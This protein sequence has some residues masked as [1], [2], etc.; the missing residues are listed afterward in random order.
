MK[1]GLPT[2]FS[3]VRHMN[4]LKNKI[5]NLIPEDLVLLDLIEDSSRNAFK[6]V[7]D[8]RKHMNLKSTAQLARRVQDSGLLEELYP[9]GYQLEVTSPGID[10]PLQHPFQFEKN[11]GQ[12]LKVHCFDG[13]IPIIL[14]LL[15]VD[16]SGF[17][18]ITKNGENVKF[19]YK[20]I[21]TAKVL[22]EFS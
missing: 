8:G 14:K 17:K 19:E 5:K 20:N 21:Q 1:S 16:E 11:V 13:D 22:I 6:L 7:V 18:G 4:N 3:F 10:A 12:K 15:S 2:H 9:A